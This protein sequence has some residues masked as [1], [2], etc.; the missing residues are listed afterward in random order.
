MAMNTTT[1]TPLDIGW[2]LLAKRILTTPRRL[3]V[4]L[5]LARA[6]AEGCTMAELVAHLGNSPS[7]IQREIADLRFMGLVQVTHA[8][9]ERFTL[10]EHPLKGY[11]ERLARYTQHAPQVS[12]S[13]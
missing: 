6:G 2:I 3:D 8:A 11:V 13:S 10:A 4:L 5:V 7:L 9:P 1:W 12:S